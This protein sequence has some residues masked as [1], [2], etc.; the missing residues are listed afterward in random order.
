MSAVVENQGKQ[1]VSLV[2]KVR[3]AELRGAL[4]RVVK[5]LA[6]YQ[7]IAVL[8]GVHITTQGHGLILRATDM[9]VSIQERVPAAV[10]QTGEAVV[11]ARLL[12][13]LLVQ[14]PKTAEWA[15]LTWDR[16]D[17][18]LTLQWDA[19]SYRLGGYAPDQFPGLPDGPSSAVVT[20]EAGALRR[21]LERVRWAAG[22]DQSKPWLT[23][24]RL[25]ISDGGL[26]AITTNGT[27]IGRAWAPAIGLA[28]QCESVIIPKRSVK[29]MAAALQ[30]TREAAV[31]LT[32]RDH[33][34][35]LEAGPVTVTSRLLEGQYPDVE[36]F[37]P[38]AAS[39]VEVSRG[40]L[41]GAMKRFCALV[42]REPGIRWSTWP[43]RDM[44]IAMKAPELAEAVE[45]FPGV[46][47]DG[48]TDEFT[49]GFN[50]QLFV[51]AL[52]GWE[53]ERVRIEFDHGVRNPVRVVAVGALPPYDAVILPL[54]TF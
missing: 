8:N 19:S 18:T 54:I 43:D 37:V 33:S 31:T 52:S 21:M 48:L 7:S 24:V 6:A 39:H 1:V 53:A 25:V 49:V 42:S 38:N 5:A 32:I 47:A 45:R 44:E 2:A 34:I 26:K 50:A 20:V 13:R 28:G 16:R 27:C 3:L 36:R 41:L 23:G 12:H 4:A 22:T 46:R 14:V 30:R 29:E 40:A 10:T 17:L 9:E 51:A 11:P 15:T 35:S